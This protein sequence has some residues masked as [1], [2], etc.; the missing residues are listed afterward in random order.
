[1]LVR[2]AVAARRNSAAAIVRRYI[3]PVASGTGDGTSWAN[4]AALA[5]VLT[6]AAAVAAS[7][8]EVILGPGNY[9]AA[10]SNLTSTAAGATIKGGNGVDNAQALPGAEPVIVG[11]R[12]AWTKPG[13]RTLT[14]TRTVA[15]GGTFTSVGTVNG[16]LVNAN[17]ITIKAIRFERVHTG[18]YIRSAVANTKVEYCVGYNCRYFVDQ[19]AN[20]TLTSPI[21]RNCTV[22]GFSKP[23]VRFQGSTTGVLVEDNT[24]DSGW[25]DGDNFAMGVLLDQTVQS[26]T[27]R[28]NVIRNCVYTLQTYWQ[29]DGIVANDGVVQVHTEDNQV[30]ECADSGFDVK[31][32]TWTSLR[33]RVET[34]PRPFRNWGGLTLTDSIVNDIVKWGGNTSPAC[35]F[36]DESTFKQVSANVVG[37]TWTPNNVDAHL[38]NAMCETVGKTNSVTINAATPPTVVGDPGV[39]YSGDINYFDADTTYSAPVGWGT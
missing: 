26:A 20:L 7:G 15:G 13:T 8:G 34:T 10:S 27:I 2:N 4:A 31:A 14:D 24:F 12:D 22:T 35:L 37:G 11:D 21:V 30:Y 19:D 5:S 18:V 17:N 3:K 23:C 16:F 39:N 38:V 32:T 1:M 6:M 28:R 29:G 36:C 9:T 33:D 25:Q